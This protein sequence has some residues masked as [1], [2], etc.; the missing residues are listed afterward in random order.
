M[1]GKEAAPTGLTIQRSDI[2]A[3]EARALIEALNAEL[4]SRYPEEGATHFRLD[5]EEVVD[6][7][8]AF[9]IASVAGEP[10]GC[11]AVRRIEERTAEIKRMYVNPAER[12]RGV[13]RALLA[14]LEAEARGLGMARLVLETGLRQPEAI[15]LYERTGFS[16]IALFGEYV[17]S[18]LSVCMAK[19]L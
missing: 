18:P 4:S 13:G 17:G 9:L 19:D 12:S 14:A 15:A 16:R 6:G 8:G 3:P 7:R 11:G 2:L 1:M 5:A 10:V